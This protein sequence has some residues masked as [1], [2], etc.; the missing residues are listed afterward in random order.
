M[1]YP[2][3]Y[4]IIIY[5]DDEYYLSSGIGLC[6]SYSDAAEQLETSFGNELISITRLTLLAEDNL[7]PLPVSLLDKVENEDFFSEANVKCDSRGNLL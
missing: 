6:R 5:D 3:T 2:F 1:T 7:I 4:S